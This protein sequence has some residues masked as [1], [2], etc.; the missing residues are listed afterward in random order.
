MVERN[1]LLSLSYYEKTS[2]TGSDHDLRYRIEKKESDD[3]KELIVTAWKGKFAF[4]H[5][6]DDKKN[7]HTAPFS[8]EGLSDIV[9]WLNRF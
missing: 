6:P 1:R 4:D 3:Q 8:E 5:T 2:F 7:T 9:D